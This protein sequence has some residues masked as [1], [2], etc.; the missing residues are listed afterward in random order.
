SSHVL[1]A[2]DWKGAP[3]NPYVYPEMA[4]KFRRYAAPYLTSTGQDEIIGKIERLEQLEDISD[5]AGLLRA[6]G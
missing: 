2:T 1:T 6:G 3:S 5:L 4:D